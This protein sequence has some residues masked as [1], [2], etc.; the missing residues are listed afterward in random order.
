MSLRLINLPLFILSYL[1]MHLPVFG[2]SDDKNQFFDMSLDELIHV[3]VASKRL[4]KIEDAPSVISV[5]SQEDIRRFGARH[6]RDVLDRLVN[7]Q[8]IGSTAYPHNRTSLRGV[9]QTHLD[10]KVLILLNGRPIREAGQG[11]V[12]GDIYSTFPLEIIQQIEVIRGP[13]SVLYG[14]NA[15]AGVI[16]IITLHPDSTFSAELNAQYGSFD[17]KQ[18]A[19]QGAGYVKQVSFLGA[20]SVHDSEGDRFSNTAGEFGPN[21]TYE[22]GRNAWQG[23][24]QLQGYDFNI[25]ALRNKV[26]QKS[27]N[28]VLTFPSEDW[29]IQRSFIDIGHEKELNTHWQLNTNITFNGMENTAGIIGGTGRF[30]TTSSKS[31][32]SEIALHGKL[33]PKSNIIFGSNYETIT[34]DNVSDGVLNTDIDSWNSSLYSQFDYRFSN[35]HKF[36]FGIQ[37]NKAKNQSAK[38]SPRIASIIKVTPNTILKM[39]YDEAFRSPYGLDL[40]LNASFL[41]GNPDLIPETINTYTTQISYKKLQ[42][43][44]ALTL[45]KSHHKDLIVRT[46]GD[47]DLVTLTNQGYVD[48]YGSEIEYSFKLNSHWQ[49]DGNMSYQTNEN[50]LNQEDA[51]F[52]PNWMIKNGLSYN[53]HGIKVGTFLSYFGAPTQ[54]VEL[55]PDVLEVNPDSTEYYLLSA[56]LVFELGEIINQAE[57]KN[58]ELSLYADNLL[59]EKV[60]YPEISRLQVNSIPSHAGIGFYGKL[61]Y[62][63]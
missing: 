44:F 32:L 61:A 6:L 27:A 55:N 2:Q 1:L 38:L 56:N 31:Y 37:S 5:I 14:S 39:S 41:Q 53:N 57:F 62:R 15:F 11:G 48:Y 25:Q 16:N 9:T 52:H 35:K 43:Y 19:L 42:H 7:A 33:S 3:T 46:I 12:N 49:I 51:T 29:Q 58:L 60:Y 13:G 24:F 45:Y 54:A 59:D 40:F 26:K 18:V 28:N 10:D 50:D 34:G 4:E 36:S 23:M 8:I 20:L 30:F 17:S 47:D 63:F 22:T 21:G